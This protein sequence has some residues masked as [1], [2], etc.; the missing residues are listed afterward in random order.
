M[1]KD[2][3]RIESAPQLSGFI[4]LAE[5]DPVPGTNALSKTRQPAASKLAAEA[6]RTS[7]PMV[8][9]AARWP[10]ESLHEDAAL[11]LNPDTKPVQ[12]K[13]A[14]SAAKPL[15]TRAQSQ[16]VAAPLAKRSSPVVEL[17]TDPVILQSP[18]RRLPTVTVP[19][20]HTVASTPHP[21]LQLVEEPLPERSVSAEPVAAGPAPTATSKPVVRLTEAEPLL[22]ALQPSPAASDLPAPTPEPR[23]ADEQIVKAEEIEAF[24]LDLKPMTALSIRTK[25][26][27]GELP[28]N[29]A[30]ARFAREREV[31]HRMGF[32]RSTTETEFM[33]EAPAV[34]HRP[35]YFEDINLE[36]HGYKVPIFQP[37]LS[38]A[39]FFGRVPLLPYMMMSE[40]HRNCQYTLGH[41]RPGDYAP[42]SL[43][44]PRL[45]LD[46]SAAEAAVVA[47]VF[48]VFP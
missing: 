20:R 15:G 12:A 40:G 32:S 33:W 30:A 13:P 22:A 18:I 43:Y 23:L 26:E 24:D 35:L 38:A 21:I 4:Q 6:S 34:C 11:A 14:A 48:F 10:V 5:R 39:H 9:E 17:A 16:D 25:P 2:Q 46:A 27:A 19:P 47:G 7:K 42:Y 37:A 45:R 28:K 36:R 44:V 8:L 31:P 29:Y 3:P 41:Y 1:A